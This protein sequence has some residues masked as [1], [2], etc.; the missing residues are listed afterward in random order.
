MGRT[1]GKIKFSG[2][3]QQLLLRQKERDI[4]ARKETRRLELKLEARER[5]TQKEKMAVDKLKRQTELDLKRKQLEVIEKTSSHG[6]VCS[7]FSF[8]LKKA[9]T[10]DWLESNKDYLQR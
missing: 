10:S 5:E 3:G 7:F 6:S 4:A 8:P 2:N 1:Q 9:K